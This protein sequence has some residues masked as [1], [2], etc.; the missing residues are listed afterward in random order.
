VS[1]PSRLLARAVRVVRLL[2]KRA[3]TVA[4][5]LRFGGP[6][7]GSVATRYADLGAKDV[8]STDYSLLPSVFPPGS[9]GPDDVLVD[10]GCGKG[11]VIQWWLSRGYRNPMV[12]LE[13][14]P[15]IGAR[16]ARRLRRFANVEIRPGN[17]VEHLPPGGTVFFLFNPFTAAVVEAFREGVFAAAQRPER[18]RLFYLNPVHIDVFERDPAWQVDHA[19]AASPW[20]E[21]PLAVVTLRGG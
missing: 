13:I 6:L 16:T 8:T 15:D 2:V 21:Y 18:V 11:R 4:L 20:S 17:A 10:V 12:G 1:A 7:G 9:I 19:I 14:D 5:D 3:G